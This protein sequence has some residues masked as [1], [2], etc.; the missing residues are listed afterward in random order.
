VRVSAGPRAVAKSHS[1][2][3]KISALM[4]SSPSTPLN[5]SMYLQRQLS[6]DKTFTRS[7]G[8]HF[9]VVGDRNTG[10]ATRRA[11]AA[12]VE[13]GARVV[14]GLVHAAGVTQFPNGRRMRVL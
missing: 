7:R 1:P 6:G 10:A 14:F 13:V 3:A 4:S 12:G 8:A 9:A 2:R 11:V 5:S